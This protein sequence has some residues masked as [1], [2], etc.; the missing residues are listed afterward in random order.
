VTPG[1]SRAAAALADLAHTLESG[2][3]PEVRIQHAAEQIRVLLGSDVCVFASTASPVAPSLAIAPAL[4]PAEEVRLGRDAM[5]LLQVVIDR[6][7]RGP[8][9][10]STRE[11]GGRPH[12]GMPLIAVGEVVGMILVEREGAP[13]GEAELQ[14]LAVAAS[15][16]GTYLAVV[17]AREAQRRSRAAL[18]EALAHAKA[19]DERKAEFLTVL[20]HE[21][22][23]PL[24][25]LRNAVSVLDRADPASD[26]AERARAVIGRQVE[27]L[28]HLVDDL[29]DAS[30]ISTGKVHLRRARLDLADVVRRTVEDHRAVFARGGVDLALSVSGAPVWV[31]ADDTRLAQVIGNL[32]GNA[33]K[34]TSAGG[35]VEVSVRPD[36]AVASVAVR[37]DGVGMTAETLERLFDPFAQGLDTLARSHAG[38]GLGLSLAKGLVELHGGTIQ[39][40]SGGAGRGSELTVTLPLVAAPAALA[41]PPPAE[42]TDRPPRRVLVIDDNR[43]AAES[44]R[45]LLELRGHRVEVAF[46]GAAAI[47]LARATSFDVVL[48]DLGMPGMNGYDVARALRE[49]AA[50]HPVLVALTGFGS[51]EHQARAMDAGFH[52][53]LVKPVALSALDDLLAVAPPAGADDR[54]APPPP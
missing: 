35:H 8:G 1:L 54:G 41:T 30:R 28:A 29:L 11:G 16:L 42:A 15:Q 46:D 36:A 26:G 14:L 12:L 6:G 19:S 33:L 3:Q 17:R 51:A 44:L 25:P 45:D 48:C 40:R 39:A 38:L 20:S 22:R 53:H 24:A 21:L 52:R 37:D 5:A 18:E 34:F 49:G 47:A 31:D 10:G 43:D 2:E 7:G 13:Y 32:L 9:A 50:G 27:H 4:A 23:N